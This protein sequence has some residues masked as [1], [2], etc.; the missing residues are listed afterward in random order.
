MALAIAG[1][2]MMPNAIAQ[3]TQAGQPPAEQQPIAQPQTDQPRIGDHPQA[4]IHD[5]SAITERERLGVLSRSS[6]LIGSKITD[7]AGN[8]LGKIRDLSVDLSAGRVLQVIVSSG[9]I[10]GFGARDV[11]VPASLLT[12]DGTGDSV[13]SRID[14]EKFQSAPPFTYNQWNTSTGR[15]LVTSSYQHFA[16]EP[17]FQSD[18]RA[19]DQPGLSARA[20][21]TTT[22]P[23]SVERASKLVGMDVANSANEDIGE[24]EDLVL[25]LAA[26][27]VNTVLVSTGGFLGVG[28]EL[29]AVPPSLFQYDRENEKLTLQVSKDALS[30]GPRYRKDDWSRYSNEEGVRGVYQAY[31]VQPYFDAD[32]TRINVRDRDNQSVTPADQGSSDQ[33]IQMTRDIRR[34]VV[35]AEGLSVTAQNVKIITQG[36]HVVLRGPVNSMAEKS[37]IEEIARLYAGPN[38]VESQLEVRAVD[39]DDQE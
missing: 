33:D 20:D 8:D 27:R 12:A 16:V 7:S 35:D 32:N 19:T 17:R 9:G 31:G 38:Q 29:S 10:F 36:G 34:A 6:D 26:G 13:A 15:D 5:A 4:G 37:R 30:I 28:D 3:Q 21:G 11:A 24:V 39:P 25:D 18:R 22:A 14:K 23:W 2:V 1:A